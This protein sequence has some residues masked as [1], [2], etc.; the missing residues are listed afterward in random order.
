VRFGRL[1]H[2]KK[3]RKYP[4]KRDEEGRSL[5][6]RCFE[7]FKQNKRPTE[8]AEELKMNEATA[9]RYFRDWK[10]LGPNFEQHYSYLKSLFNKTAPDRDKSIQLFARACGI[11]KEQL[12]TILSRP[13]GLR[14]LMT[15]KLYFPAYADADHKRH[16][17]L[18]LA[19]LIS[20]HLVKH[21]GHFQDVYL[22]LRRYIQENMKHREEE[23]A[24]I[25]KENEWLK[26]IRTIITAEMGRERQGRVKTDTFSEEE[27]NV[28]I[29]WGI[30]LEARE[31]Q[32]WYWLCIGKLTAE[33]LTTDQARE[34]MYQNLIEKGNQKAAKALRAFQDKV[35][36]LK[37]NKGG[38]IVIT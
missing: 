21:G 14:R 24:G 13:H 32:I 23:D 1:F 10:R 27:R 18:E 22:A 3:P 2:P 9:Y 25:K 20:E 34:K 16:V 19:L 26:F 33:G 6:E 4:I 12:E 15:K 28:I 17:A 38:A 7:E 36:P 5:R 35:H 11:E 8:V 31:A 30:E 37:T 29:K